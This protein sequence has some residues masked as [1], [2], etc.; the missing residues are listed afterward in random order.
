VLNDANL[1]GA[2]LL[3]W[4]IDE[5]VI[6]AGWADNSVNAGPV[7]GVA[8]EQADGLETWRSAATAAMPATPGPAAPPTPCSTRPACRRAGRTTAPRRASR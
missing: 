2:G 5:D 4:H 1:P 6:A 3:V 7:Y 8:L